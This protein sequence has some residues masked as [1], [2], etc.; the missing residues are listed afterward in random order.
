MQPRF[1][2]DLSRDGEV[3]VD[4]EG[5]ELESVERA[6][7]VAIEVATSA[8]RDQFVGALADP[9]IV[10]VRDQTGKQVVRVTL[11]LTVEHPDGLGH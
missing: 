8:A 2:F 4:D 7:E 10:A 3:V 6:E 9:L 5:D 1:Y 11:A